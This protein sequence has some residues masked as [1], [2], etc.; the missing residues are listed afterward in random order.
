[1]STPKV[2]VI[3]PTYNKARYLDLSL[4]SW[5]HQRC[6]DYELIIVDDGS[7]DST[8]EVLRKYKD[9]LPARCVSIDHRGRA[10]ARNRGLD[11]ARALSVGIATELRAKGYRVSSKPVCANAELARDRGA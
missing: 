3:V 4:A 11:K 6:S 1:M 8:S 9:R 2:S 5:C 10:F 7:T